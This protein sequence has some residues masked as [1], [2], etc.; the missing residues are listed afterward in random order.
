MS[1]SLKRILFAIGGAVGLVILLAGVV[2]LVVDANRFKPRLEVA[3]S[4]A[5]GMDVR[6]DGRLGMGF[7]PGF[8]VTVA[9]VRV[10]GERAVV[11]AAAKKVGLWIELLPLLRGELRLRRVDLTEPRLSVERDAEGRFNV[12][13]MKQAA[14]LLGALDGARVSVTNGELRC[15]DKR[16]GEE[17]EATAIDLNLSH[18]RF[19][20][21]NGLELLKGLSLK[22]ELSCG[23][24][25]TKG[26]SLSA[27]RVSI[28]GKDGVFEVR[29]VTMRIFGGQLAGEIQADCSGPVPACQIRC[30]LPHF[31]IEEFLKTL[32]PE[33]AAQGAMDFSASLSMRGRTM[34]QMVQTATG[35]VSLRGEN[36]IL[37]GN[38]LDRR[39]ARFES[40]QNFNLVDVGAVFFAGPL[41]LAI[42]KGY[43]FAS[44]FRGPGGSSRVRTL[45]SDWKVERGVAQARDVA[46][47][48]PRNRI[49]LQGGLDFVNGSFADVT[50]AM[51]DAKGCA[52]VRQEIH[53]SFGKPVVEKPR[54]LT[55]LAGPVVHLYTRTRGLFPAGPCEP[56]YSGSVAAPE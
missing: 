52:R 51:I 23:A 5:L 55:S 40:S 49:A 29:P 41:G 38:D 26:V 25:R 6:I 35:E 1:R 12:E 34:S 11:V 17:L 4:D 42:T 27:V 8:H 30:S 13:G 28:R 56:F 9:E 22:A 39:L 44:L 14:T 46:L 18:M 16:S 54:V 48:T 53:G 20:K 47:A 15:A 50:L 10:L 3:A 37:V 2:P 33:K 36:L 43:S 7:L 19:R 24:I 21:P 32:S 31:R 45:V